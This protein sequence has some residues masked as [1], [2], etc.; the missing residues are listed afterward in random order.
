MDDSRSSA[1]VLCHAWNVSVIS[2]DVMRNPLSEN[3][4]EMPTASSQVKAEIADVRIATSYVA[5]PV[6][7]TSI[8][9]K[10]QDNDINET[11]ILIFIGCK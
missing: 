2:D 11:R 5:P 6:D 10:K 8:T 4:P 9:L 1:V 3:R 7:R